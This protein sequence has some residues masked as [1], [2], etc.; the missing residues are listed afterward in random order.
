MWSILKCK[1]TPLRIK[2]CRFWIASDVAALLRMLRRMIALLLTSL[3]VLMVLLSGFHC[4]ASLMKMKS[5]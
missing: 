3:C 4:T 2:L 1:D 5:C